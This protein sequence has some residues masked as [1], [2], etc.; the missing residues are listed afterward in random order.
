[1]P[2]NGTNFNK[3]FLIDEWIKTLRV[4]L[5]NVVIFIQITG[6][7]VICNNLDG[8]GKHDVK[9]NKWGTEHKCSIISLIM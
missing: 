9:W 6:N 2:R 8:T 4:H 1:L 3:F 5:H 7:T